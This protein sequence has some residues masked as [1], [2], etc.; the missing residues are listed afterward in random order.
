MAGNRIK[1]IT[2][3]IGGDTTKLQ[4]ALK[5]VNTEIRSTHSKLKDVEKLLVN[6]KYFPAKNG[7]YFPAVSGK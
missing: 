2:I 4:T 3:E 1:G 7:N 6:G 5:G